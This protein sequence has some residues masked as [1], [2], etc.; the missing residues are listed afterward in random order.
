VRDNALS[1]E[2]LTLGVVGVGQIGSRVAAWA[3]K[4][5]MNVLEND[6]PK[7]AAGM[8]GLVSLEEIAEKC[9]IITFHP[10]LNVEGEYCSYHLAD[11]GFFDSLR[12]CQLFINASRGPVVD[13]RALL[14]ALEDGR[15][16][17]AAID[18]WENEPEIDLSLLNKVYVATPH[19]AGYSAEGKINATRMVLEAFAR[20]VGYV[21]ELPQLQLDAPSCQVVEACSEQDALLAIYSP[22]DD[23][24]MLKEAPLQ[25]ENLRN[26]YVLRREPSAYKIV[27]K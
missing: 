25:F 11:T 2:G 10:T 4:V 13:N 27:I 7:A 14:S 16:S 24:V 3:R 23:T 6:P 26:N 18:V 1:V 5:G 21:G 8:V 19:I 20:F 12:R 9:D 17:Y 15:V 22:L